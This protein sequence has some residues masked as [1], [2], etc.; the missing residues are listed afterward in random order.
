LVTVPA[1][2][3]LPGVPKS[4]AYAQLSYRQ[5]KFFTYVEA[6]YRSRVPVDDV[7]SEF[8][9]AY[10][11]LNFVVGLVQQAP[12][13]RISEYVRLD[14]VADRDYAGS[15]IVNDGSRRFYEPALGRNI[16]AGIQVSLKL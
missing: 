13:W 16:N 11:V 10:T 8:A 9:D 7:N 6:L 3:M 12:G 4:Q 1:G 5:P 14:N 15:V 2:N